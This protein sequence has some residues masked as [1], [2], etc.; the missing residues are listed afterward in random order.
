M[1][2]KLVDVPSKEVNMKKVFVILILAALV[3]LSVSMAPGDA[4][5]GVYV[6]GGVWI[7]PG[8]GPG[9]SPYY[10]YPYYPYNPYYAAPP[11][12]IQQQ[13][14]NVSPPPQQEDRGYWYFCQNP[15]GYYPYVKQCPNG[16]MKVVPSTAPPTEKMENA[17]SPDMQDQYR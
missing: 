2:D 9:Y 10:P 15:Q 4:S 8:W 12:V 14:T 3:L 7:G 11:A 5:A 1:G 6:R 16:W 17:P 13:P